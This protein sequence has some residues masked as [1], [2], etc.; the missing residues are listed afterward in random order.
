MKMKRYESKKSKDGVQIFELNPYAKDSNICAVIGYS[1][2]NFDFGYDE[3]NSSCK[4]IKLELLIK[5]KEC[6][7]SGV[8]R[9]VAQIVPGVGMW[10]CELTLKLQQQFDYP[11]DLCCVIPYDG[12]H[13]RWAPYLQERL[14]EIIEN[15]D[16]VV[17]CEEPHMQTKFITERVDSVLAVI[18]DKEPESSEELIDSIISESKERRISISYL[19]PIK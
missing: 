3:D 5:M 9:F 4:R 18:S 17:T 8:N 2:K 11:V 15:A 7:E 6:I 13:Y 1:S 19:N 14:H 12:H 10:A 16:S